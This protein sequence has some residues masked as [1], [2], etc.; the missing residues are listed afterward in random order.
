MLQ[1]TEELYVPDSLCVCGVWGVLLIDPIW[2]QFSKA[3]HSEIPQVRQLKHRLF[4]LIP[5]S[6]DHSAP[7][8]LWEPSPVEVL[9]RPCSWA[10]PSAW[11][12]RCSPSAAPVGPGGCSRPRGRSLHGWCPRRA[13]CPA[14]QWSCRAGS[15]WSPFHPYPCGTSPP[16]RQQNDI[17]DPGRDLWAAPSNKMVLNARQEQEGRVVNARFTNIPTAPPPS[18]GCQSSWWHQLAWVKLSPGRHCSLRTLAFHNTLQPLG[19]ELLSKPG[20]GK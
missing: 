14:C 20:G 19:R 13:A 15:G 9:A 5:P 8:A 2:A 1:S 10:A 12:C 17:Y 16:E 11:C 18:S 7:S 6:M 4:R 3:W